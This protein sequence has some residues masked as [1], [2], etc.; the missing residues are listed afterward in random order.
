MEEEE[1]KNDVNV[2]LT[3]LS[4]TNLFETYASSCFDGR[5]KLLLKAFAKVIKDNDGKL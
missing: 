4:N 2:T 1:F 5:E 3:F